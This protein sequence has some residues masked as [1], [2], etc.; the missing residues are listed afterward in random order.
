MKSIIRC[1][2]CVC[3]YAVMIFIMTGCDE[4]NLVDIDLQ[5]YRMFLS[6]NEVCAELFLQN[7]TERGTDE[8]THEAYETCLEAY[9]SFK[10]YWSEMKQM[11]EMS[12]EEIRDALVSNAWSGDGDSYGNMAIWN[13]DG[14]YELKRTTKSGRLSTIDSGRFEVGVFGPD[15]RKVLNLFHEGDEVGWSVYVAIVGDE[16][17]LYEASD[18][19]PYMS[20]KKSKSL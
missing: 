2:L 7:E 6:E 8:K 16:L 18:F 20:Y 19:E 14:T 12:I 3:S 11:Q 13:E 9:K 10:N 1:L 5:T 15:Q 17:R 4:E